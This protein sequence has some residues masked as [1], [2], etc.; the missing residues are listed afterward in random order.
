MYFELLFN[1]QV[2]VPHSRHCTVHFFPYPAALY[3]PVITPT[4]QM[5][6]LRLRGVKSLPNIT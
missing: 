6:K 2:E 1:K 3:N 5:R 4:L